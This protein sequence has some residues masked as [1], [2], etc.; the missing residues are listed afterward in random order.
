VAK[1]LYCPTCEESFAA[2][3]EVTSNSAI[4]KMD[5]E[6]HWYPTPS[7]ADRS[8]VYICPRDHEYTWHEGMMI[9]K[10]CTRDL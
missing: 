7:V 9:C 4:H 2:P 5:T 3:D 1:A 8:Q 6:T 10:E